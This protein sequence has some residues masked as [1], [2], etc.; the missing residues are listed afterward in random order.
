MCKGPEC[1]A[2]AGKGQ[3]KKKSNNVYGVLKESLTH[4]D[5]RWYT[6][7]KTKPECYEK[8]NKDNTRESSQ[9]F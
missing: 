8:K 1:R 2:I 6:S 9:K 5:S 7:I 4:W 3:V